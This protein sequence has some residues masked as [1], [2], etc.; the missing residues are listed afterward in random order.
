M[1]KLT[2]PVPYLYW[3]ALDSAF[4]AEGNIPL[5]SLNAVLIDQNIAGAYDSAMNTA[6]EVGGQ[7]IGGLWYTTD[8]AYV[9]A[10]SPIQ[11]AVDVLAAY[12]T[13]SGVWGNVS[14][15][16]GNFNYGNRSGG[17]AV[18]VPESGMSFYLGGSHGLSGLVRLNA[19]DAADLMWTNETLGDGSYGTAVPDLAG[20][21]MVYVPAGKEGVLVTFGGSNVCSKQLRSFVSAAEA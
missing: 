5:S 4:P 2:R 14:V 7:H 18:S 19:S 16:G 1:V 12:N 8:T 13:T 17:A 11:E 15:S 20:H 10:G 6:G 9:Y 21:N 3:V